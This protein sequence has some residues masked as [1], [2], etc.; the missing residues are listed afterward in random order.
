MSNLFFVRPFA[1]RSKAS[2]MSELS[3]NLDHQTWVRIPND[4][5]H[6]QG[7]FQLNQFI[8]KQKLRYYWMEAGLFS[9]HVKGVG[10][11]KLIPN[12]SSLCTGLIKPQKRIEIKFDL[13]WLVSSTTYRKRKKRKM[14]EFS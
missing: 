1:F 12:L 4:L 5:M 11:W 7:S 3:T 14:K 10:I 6:L 8:I 9:V 13:I 2:R